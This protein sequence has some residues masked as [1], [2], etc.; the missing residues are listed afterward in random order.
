[1]DARSGAL[2]WKMK[3]DDHPA[4]LMTASPSLHGDT[5]YVPVSSVEEASAASPGYQCCNF[6]GSVLALDAQTGGVEWKTYLVGEAKAPA[7]GESVW[8]PSGVAVWNSP[9]IDVKRGQLTIA[10]G[11]NYSTPATELSD[12]IIA[13]DLK[14]GAIKWHYQALEGDAWNVACYTQ[15]G[16]NC[17]MD[18]GPDFDFGAGTVLAKGSDGRELV[19]AGQ[20]SGIVYGIDPDSGKLVWE[21][22]VGRGSE[23]GGIVFGLA[24]A[25]GKVFAPVSDRVIGEV[26]GFPPKPGVFGIDIATGKTLWYAESPADTCGDDKACVRGYGGSLS[27]T[28]GLVFAGAD[29]AHLR[30]LDA[31]TGKVLHDIDTGQEFETV[32]GVPA[33]GGA[34][35]GGVTAVAHKG[36]LIVASGYGF[37][38]KMPGNVLLVF[39]AK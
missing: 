26:D 28:P 36:Q 8:G 39:E 20:K 38:S 29:D 9:S 6:R 2:V 27:A 17:D 11:D 14:T 18:A 19:L 33:K 21:N 16:S 4:A 30:I 5:L 32:N 13:L 12:S 1:L 37:A 35:S 22:K 34:I 31:D 24:A 25:D 7:E 10:T 3:A 23:G 15:T